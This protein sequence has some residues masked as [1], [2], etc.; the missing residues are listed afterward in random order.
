M[1]LIQQII[2]GNVWFLKNEDSGEE[3]RGQ[4]IAENVRKNT[5][6]RYSEQ[7]ALNRN[8]PIVQFV[9]GNLKTI[10]FSTTLFNRDIL[11]GSIKNEQDTL[12]KLESW[13]ERDEELKRPPILS[14][15]I[16]NGVTGFSKCNLRSVEAVIGEPVAVSGEFKSAVVDLTLAKYVPFSLE[17]GFI[18]ETRYHRA[19]ERDYYEWLTQREYGSAIL[20]DIIRKRHPDK[21]NIEVGEIIKLPSIDAI[22]TERVEQKS[23]PLKTSFG[24]RLTS[25]KSLRLEM[26]ELHNVDYVSHVI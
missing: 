5:S 7:T 15:W 12:E 4:F 24:K 20:G 21:L 3:I 26:F 22:K 25:Q 2:R 16:G 1:S 17:E 23:I 10:T 14:F 19:K 11:F 6:T 9:S 18:G 8:D 13:V